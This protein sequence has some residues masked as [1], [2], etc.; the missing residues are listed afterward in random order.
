MVQKAVEP[1]TLCSLIAPTPCTN[2]RIMWDVPLLRQD[3]P[4]HWK[5]GLNG[6]QAQRGV[7][8]SALFSIPRIM[9]KT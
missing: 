2:M 3:C 8:I 5:S 6:L 9:K 1:E 4:L 7:W